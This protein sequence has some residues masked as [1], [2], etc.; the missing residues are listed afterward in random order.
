MS[1]EMIAIAVDEALLRELDAIAR[2]M[3]VSR[4][5]ACR[6][7]LK[8]GVEHVRGPAQLEI[9]GVVTRGGPICGHSR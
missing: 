2:S 8:L 4:H 6:V 7:C 5:D 3:G 9:G 1:R